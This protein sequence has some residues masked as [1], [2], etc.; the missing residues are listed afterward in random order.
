MYLLSLNDCLHSPHKQEQFWVLLSRF[1]DWNNS[2]IITEKEIANGFSVANTYERPPD[3]SVLKHNYVAIFQPL[4]F[5]L[6]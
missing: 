2:E 1:L 5:T 3:C 6:T 4:L